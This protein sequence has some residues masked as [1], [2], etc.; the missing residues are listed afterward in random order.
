MELLNKILTER[1]DRLL[2]EERS[3]LADLQV[4]LAGHDAE[5]D[6]LKALERSIRQ[7]DELFL[8]VVAGGFNSGKSVFIN[9][10]P[11]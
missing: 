5:A 10:L 1:Q 2:A 4:I 11:F 7:L 6:D 8:L 9:A 3:R